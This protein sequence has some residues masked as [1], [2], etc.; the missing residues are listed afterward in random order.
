MIRNIKQKIAAGSG[1][2][3][4]VGL[5]KT[6]E[7]RTAVKKAV[8]ANVHE[9]HHEPVGRLLKMSEVVMLTGMCRSSI[10]NRLR[11]GDFVR[12]VKVGPRSVRFPESEVRKWIDDRLLQRDAKGE[13]YASA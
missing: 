4:G 10:Y 7:A 8:F 11:E 12:H 1:P 9:Y 3:T 2:A 13:P 6:P 5:E